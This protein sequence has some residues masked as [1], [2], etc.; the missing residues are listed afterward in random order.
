MDTSNLKQSALA[1]IDQHQAEF[2]QAADT[3]WQN[4]ELPM[5]EHKASA[6]LIGLLEKNGFTVER[7]VAGM[8]TAFIATY[9]KGHPVIGLSAEYDC[10][11]GLS[12]KVGIEQEP[13]KS[14][15]PGH[16][17]GHNLLGVGAVQAAIALQEVIKSNQLSGTLKVFGT[18]A[19]ELCIGKPFMA[20]EGLFKDVDLFLDWHPWSYN[21]ADYDV[22]SAYFNIKYHFKGK[23]T[24]GSTPWFGRS[25]LDAALLMA[26]AVEMLREHIPPASS[27]EAANTINFTFSQVGPEIPNVV[28]DYT[29]AW[30]VGRLE[31]TELMVDVI[32]RVNKCAQGAALATETSVEI[33]LVTATHDKLPNKILAEVMHKNLTEI[34]SPQFTQEEQEFV[35]QMERNMGIKTPAGLDKSILPFGGGGSVL[36][37]TSE[38][39]WFA[40]YAT[41]WVTLAPQN[42]GWHNW[43]VV[44]CAGS[45]I[46]KKTMNI[47]AK[48]L[49][50]SAI[51]AITDPE[52]VVEAR[53]EW[54]NRTAARNF[55]KILP[56]EVMPPIDINKAN[57]AKYL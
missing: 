35:K 6:L 23:A 40:P 36:C 57:M 42:M 18:A 48:V 49:T 7:G 26:H 51:D 50:A 21:R 16:G 28:P 12:Q 25:S 53:K 55:I 8:P 39:S 20:R 13:V 2:S 19:E 34:G 31:T 17:C 46:G 10:L 27:Q 30:Y 56:D 5:E 3:L 15:A 54:R 45:S 38:Y 43:I 14:G 9:G 4:P 1:W 37:D 52:L 47:A 24:H 11:P 32:D 33:E 29:T 22:C 41:T 44:S